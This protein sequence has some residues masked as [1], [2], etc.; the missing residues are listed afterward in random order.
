MESQLPL[1]MS[2]S[3]AYS[4]GVDVAATPAFT[5]ST[6]Q[7][8][9]DYSKDSDQEDSEGRR[10]GGSFERDL[11]GERESRRYAPYSTGARGKG[12]VSSSALKELRIYV[13]NIPYTTRWQ[14]L[15]DYMKKGKSEFILNV[16]QNLLSLTMTP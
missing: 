5:A 1:G 15:K 10:R 16:G 14:E 4:L 8:T 6:V 7:D 3:T 9:T 2:Y 12:R 11:R 13:S